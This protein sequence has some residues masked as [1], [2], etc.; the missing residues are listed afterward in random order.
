MDIQD[1]TNEE[2]QQ[3]L[4]DL[5]F[6]FNS[7]KAIKNI[8]NGK[9]IQLEQ[10]LAIAL[11]EIKFQ[12]EEKEK[13]AAELIIANLELKFQ[14]EENAKHAAELVIANIE[15]VFQNREKARIEAEL[16]IANKALAFLNEEKEKQAAELMIALEEAKE[17]EYFLNRS[18]VA[19]EIG[20][21]KADYKKQ[22]FIYSKNLYKIFGIDE[23]FDRSLNGFMNLV[24]PDDRK[25]LND[26][27]LNEILEK[28]TNFAKEYRI[29]RNNDKA[30]RWMQGYGDTTF[31]EKGNLSEMIGTIQDIS[32]RKLK[33]LELAIITEKAIDFENKFKQ[34]A[35][36]IDEVFW[37]RTES[38]MIYVSPS[39]E[40]IWGV[41]CQAIYENPQIFAEIIHPEDKTIVKEIIQSNEFKEKGLFNYEYRIIRADNQV[42][43]INAKTV[44]I[45]DDSGQII[46]RVGIA[47]DITEKYQTVQELIQAKEQAEES[48]RL[49]SAFLANMSHEIRTPMNG[50]L[51]FAS[52]LKEPGLTGE[53]QQEY[54]RII[55]KSGS[56]MLNIINDIVDISKIEAGLMNINIK[57]TDI[58]EKIE[59]I[60]IF[61]KPQVEEKGMK[62]HFK[63]T[64]PAKEAIIRTDNE[65]V[66]SI[67]TNL[68]KNAIK[69]SKE[70]E[71]EFGYNLKKDSK[72]GSI[73]QS[74]SVE[75][76]FYVKDTGIGIPKNRQQAI[77][78][79]FV[80]ADI[81]DKM[82]LQ[83]A[84]L[85]LSISK[86]YVEMLGGKIWV[87]SEEGIGS[88]FYFTLPYNV[89]P[90]GKKTVEKN[91]TAQDE[92]NQINPKVTG[93]KILIAEDDETSE[94]LLSITL[95]AF[96]KEVIDV[97]TGNE[98]VKIC[99]NN[100]D[101][102]LILM[103]I[104]LPDLNGYEAT[105]QI[106]Q[107]NKDV[108]IIAQ[109]AFGLSGDREKAIEAG[110]NDYISKPINKV[111]LLSLIYKYFKK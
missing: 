33:E 80:Q 88:C 46:K 62:L 6:E 70:G 76:E 14:N 83:G 43:W 94:M 55:E 96:S 61:F 37:L 95:K 74:R 10:E 64:L 36:N 75:L 51:G 12:N 5:Q 22:L 23:N 34:I 106:R 78:E 59:F 101:I 25:M 1:K 69:Y 79:R 68:V 84:G 15:L 57:E 67:L 35:E 99:R 9:R 66:Y 89:K 72:P 63:N 17:S 52:L 91:V 58:N 111:E 39:F 27:I 85:G 49:K 104:Q 45:V 47:S 77:F 56:R 20:S 90:E 16:I 32:E 103:D 110:C 87:E 19:G 18:Q 44:P 28:N 48:D 102:D 31:D 82:A 24:H 107:F 108:I 30:I 29:L 86:A 60:Y 2:L 40:K 11:Q 13:R 3:E 100:P 42:R 54:I 26:Y 38:E 105:R 71:I 53:R 81:S 92:K 7:L 65:K 4:K 93:L 50:I 41:P 73:E 98:A 109:T 97:R 21:Y 8:S